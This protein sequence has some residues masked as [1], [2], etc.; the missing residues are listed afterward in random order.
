MPVSSKDIDI[1]LIRKL[2]PLDKVDSSIL[3]KILNKFS[4]IE[5]PAGR[6]I[7][8]QG[9]INEWVI[10]LL[11]GEVELSSSYGSSEIIK[12]G[13]KEALKPLARINPRRISAT[14]KTGITLLMIQIK[15]LS[16]IISPKSSNSKELPEKPS[17]NGI[18]VYDND[19]DKNE[20][21]N[22]MSRFTCS[23]VFQQLSPSNMQAVL[24]K[25]EEVPLKKG[26]IVIKEGDRSDQYYYII[27][28][29][30]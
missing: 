10:Y 30:P 22:W 24:L 4:L 23:S 19:N 28:Q 8:K 13:T 21:N 15:I 27:K 29:G 17:L 12:S 25:L 11:S 16:P 7:F 6:T 26:K 9:E 20:D 1:N 5:L 18:M 2:I 14:A 3:A